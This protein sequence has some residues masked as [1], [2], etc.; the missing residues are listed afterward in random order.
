MCARA[1]MKVIRGTELQMIVRLRLTSSMTSV[2]NSCSTVIALLEYVTGREAPDVQWSYEATNIC[3]G[4]VHVPIQSYIAK[5]TRQA[6][7]FWCWPRRIYI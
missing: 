7:G 6:F 1:E 2:S 3:E 4:K 5:P